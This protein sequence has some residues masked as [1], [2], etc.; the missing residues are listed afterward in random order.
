VKQS[1]LRESTLLIV[2]LLLSLV[3]APLLLSQISLINLTVFAAMAMLALSMA[4][5]WGFGGILSFGQSA[6]F[7]LGGY[8][9]AI[10]VLNLGE[11]TFPILLG[12]VVPVV[13]AVG[14]GYFMFYGRLGDIYLGVITLVVSLILYQLV[15]S[16][17]GSNYRIGVAPLGGY[18][19][20]PSLPPINLPGDPAVVLDYTDTYRLSTGLLIVAYFGLRLFL[21]S[22]F[23][24]TIVAIRENERRMELLGYDV[25]G[26]KLIV[27][28]VAAGIAG[29]GGVLFANW[30]SFISPN[31][32]SV[33]FTAQ[34]IIWILVGGLGTL[35]GPVIG[36]III[37]TLVTWLGAVK[38]ADTNIV[39]G[40]L[41]VAFV[42][43]VPKGLIPAIH[44]LANRLRASD[45]G[46]R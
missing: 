29:L 30:G 28:A 14:L 26:R 23:G 37:Q 9:Y 42:L 36:S 40:V 25:R 33:A 46:D 7:G 5:V 19:G 35:I 13:F 10:A 6:F 8:A 22:H 44:D 17:S 16:T 18:N 31:V 1:L 11:S 21:A 4:L 27:F 20:I 2:A 15:S 12:I 43:F 45:R 39:L 41:F 32:F 38:F 24:K 3:V 34:I